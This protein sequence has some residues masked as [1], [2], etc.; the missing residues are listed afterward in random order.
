MEKVLDQLTFGTSRSMTKPAEPSL[1]ELHRY[2]CKAED[3]TQSLCLDG[4]G[5]RNPFVRMSKGSTPLL[6]VL[7][8]RR[9]LFQNMV[10]T[11]VCT[12]FDKEA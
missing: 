12:A 10:C 4:S 7:I 9:F 6:H 1:H 11:P 2:T 3:G 8:K 5:T